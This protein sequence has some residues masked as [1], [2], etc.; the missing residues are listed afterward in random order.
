MK[1]GSA[2]A[3]SSVKVAWRI[4]PLAGPLTTSRPLFTVMAGDDTPLSGGTREPWPEV[5]A[6]PSRP[7][8]AASA[9]ARP[10]IT[11]VRLRTAQFTIG[12]GIVFSAGRPSTITVMWQRV[13]R[14][15]TAIIYIRRVTAGPPM[16]AVIS[17]SSSAVTRRPPTGRSAIR[18]ERPTPL[19]EPSAISPSRPCRQTASRPPIAT[20]PPLSLSARLRPATRR[21][22]ETITYDLCIATRNVRIGLQSVASPTSLEGEIRGTI[23]TALGVPNEEAY[24]LPPKRPRRTVQTG[25]EAVAGPDAGST[26]ALRT[27]R[28]LGLG[29]RPPA[30]IDRQGRSRRHPVSAPTAILRPE[31]ALLTGAPLT[32]PCVRPSSRPTEVYQTTA[33][34]AAVETKA[35]PSLAP[36]KQGRKAAMRHQMAISA[37]V[38]HGRPPP[39]VA[40]MALFGRSRNVT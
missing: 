13:G 7:P 31:K 40:A 28:L 35:A 11:E 26:V 14:P 5:K 23:S 29:N 27:S 36:A 2:V 9:I 25:P 30:V 4:R 15:S 8:F 37:L 24:T 6:R 20:I 38:V 12:P 17:P 39:L 16:V 34:Q 1:A 21:P 22:A 33:K 18:V 10:F 32:K 3:S 19:P